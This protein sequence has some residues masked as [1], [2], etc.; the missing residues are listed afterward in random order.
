MTLTPE[1]VDKLMDNESVVGLMMRQL[2]REINMDGMARDQRQ[3]IVRQ[4]F[5]SMMHK[6][7]DLSSK[8]IQLAVE[9]VSSSYRAGLAPPGKA[10][11][12]ERL[13]KA[14]AAAKKRPTVPTKIDTKGFGRRAAP[15]D[16]RQQQVEPASGGSSKSLQAIDTALKLSARQAGARSPRTSAGGAANKQLDPSG[17]PIVV[18]LLPQEKAAAAA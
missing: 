14:A 9:Q 12:S 11:K 10:A 4:V 2:K 15:L 1:L 7:V 18:V 3:L 5:D 6:E 13:Q 17:N 8:N 16:T